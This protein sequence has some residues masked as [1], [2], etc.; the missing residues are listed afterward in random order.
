MYRLLVTVVSRFARF[1]GLS[2][3]ADLAE[4]VAEAVQGAGEAAP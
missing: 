2:A 1:Q 4:A 3:T